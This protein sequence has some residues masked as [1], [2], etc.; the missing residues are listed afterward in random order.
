MGGVTLKLKAMDMHLEG[1]ALISFFAERGV[2]IT[3]DPKDTIMYRCK[4]DVVTRDDAIKFCETN[5]IQFTIK[6]G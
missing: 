4:N 6:K 3:E 1:E 5:K 2:Y